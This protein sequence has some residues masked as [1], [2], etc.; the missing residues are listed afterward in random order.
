MIKHLF[1]SEQR[2]NNVWWL[3]LMLKKFIFGVWGLKKLNQIR[4]ICI[5]IYGYFTNF[6]KLHQANL[7]QAILWTLGF[8]HKKLINFLYFLDNNVLYIVLNINWKLYKY[9][10]I[11]RSHFENV[12]SVISDLY[13]LLKFRFWCLTW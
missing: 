3:E 8:Q 4:N 10:C 13:W 11:Y 5:S 7:L 9:I 6:I 2:I 1:L 12:S